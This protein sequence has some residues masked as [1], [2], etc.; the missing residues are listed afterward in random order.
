MKNVTLLFILTGIFCFNLSNA[1]S[2]LVLAKCGFAYASGS[3]DS[4]IGAMATIS[5]ENKFNKYFSLGINGKFGGVDYKEDRTF[6]ENNIPIEENNLEISN[7][8][9]SVNGFSK[10]SFV[11][12]DDII[13][14][15]VPEIG[16]YWMES[17][18]TIYFIDK[19]TID[20]THKNYDS[21][22]V[23]EISYGLHLEGQYFFTDK[24]NILASIGGNNYDIGTSLNKVDLEGD[25]SSSLNEKSFFLYFEVGIVY[26]LFG[27]NYME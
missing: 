3:L 11:T 7:T 1:Q 26:N 24:L 6:W 2:I 5:V 10:F 20:V 9:Y 4:E 21:K 8:A 17:D 12:T 18:P 14:S 25:W 19:Q 16:F 23:K 22:L 13:L 15:L 27:K